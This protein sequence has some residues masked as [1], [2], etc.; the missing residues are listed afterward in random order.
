MSKLY[1]VSFVRKI[2]LIT[3]PEKIKIGILKSN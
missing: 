1:K 3:F 2:Y